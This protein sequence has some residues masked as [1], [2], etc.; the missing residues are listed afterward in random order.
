MKKPIFIGGAGS[1]GTTLLSVILNRHPD[2]ACGPE[3]SFFNKRKI[4]TADYSLVKRNFKKW[5][6]KGL[7]TE[8]YWL[9][10]GFFLNRE[11][12]GFSDDKIDIFLKES[13]NIKDFM[14][15]F[16]EDFLKRSGK[17]RFAEKTP[18]NSYCFR[19]LQSLF[20]DAKII[21]LIRDGRDT[22]CSFK[23]KVSHPFIASSGWLYNVSAAIT[24]REQT[25]YHEE[26][27]EK[28]VSNPEQTLKRIC[29]HIE[30]EYSDTL[31]QETED[32][33]NE[34]SRRGHEKWKNN[35]RGN[36]SISS[37]GRYRREM[38][39][40]DSRIFWNTAL[41]A[42]AK[43]DLG[44]S[45]TS[46]KDLMHDLGYP[47]YERE[48]NHVAPFGLR[49]WVEKIYFDR[50]FKALRLGRGWVKRHTQLA[51]SNVDLKK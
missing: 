45:H 33:K 29:D 17:V 37:I 8:G 1:S 23:K 26:R 2:I 35:P 50:F 44:V 43:S 51:S 5:L 4:Y 41:T 46:V 24:A 22:Y 28:F 12:Y 30:V 20:P 21:H 25:N 18:S 48:A 9:Y 6:K 49:I 27:Y 15:S 19:E 34:V 32:E 38:T 7:N 36:I 16:V 42:K 40:Q 39:N 31:L 11:Y 13:S 3:M 47:F 10:P 14:E